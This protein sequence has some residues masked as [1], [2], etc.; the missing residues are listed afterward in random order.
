MKMSKSCQYLMRQC[1]P[2]ILQL[3]L[4]NNMRSRN[5]SSSFLLKALAVTSVR[6][7]LVF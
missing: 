7:I 3:W 2:E 5:K 1:P 6:D 4:L